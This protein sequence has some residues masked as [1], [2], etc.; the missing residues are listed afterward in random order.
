M[1][2]NAQYYMQI[3]NP[4]LEDYDNRKEYARIVHSLKCLV[5]D[6]NIVQVRIALMALL[7]VKHR[8]LLSRSDLE[9]T[10]VYLE[11]FHFAYNA[12]LALRTNKLEK[13]YSTFAIAL[14]KSRNKGESKQII[15]SQLITPLKRIFPTKEQFCRKFVE[16]SFSKRDMPS[17]IK[18]K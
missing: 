13:I 10:I 1:L 9:K 15:E 18:A 3:I 16:L 4:R 2:Q 12:V 17:N 14:R 6:Y 11:K 7:D 5:G 8:E